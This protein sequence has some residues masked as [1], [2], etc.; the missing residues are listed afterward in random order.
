MRAFF[1]SWL[2][3]PRLAGPQTVSDIIKA[4]MEVMPGGER[5]CPDLHDALQL[6]C[7]EKVNSRRLGYWL[8]AHRD[9]I[10]DG[11]QLQRIGEDGHAKVATWRVVKCG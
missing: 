7:S 5:S 6:V 8:R 10:V 3:I 9:R 4:G 2:D 11:M 1:G